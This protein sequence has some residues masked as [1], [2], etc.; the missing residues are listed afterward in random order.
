MS[1]ARMIYIAVFAVIGLIAGYIFF[2]RYAGDYIN[3]KTLLSF[4]GN[5]IQNAFRA[6][7]GIDEMRNRILLCGAIGAMVGLLFPIKTRK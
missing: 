1:I 3:L 6:I 5:R 7:A 2:G 4:G